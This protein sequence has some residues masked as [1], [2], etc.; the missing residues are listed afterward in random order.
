LED[1][2]AED[3]IL[4]DVHAESGFADYFIICTGTSERQLNALADAVDET[5]RKQHGLKSP[6]L[7]GHA[8]HGWVLVDFN[9][10]IIHLFSADKRKHYRLEELWHTGKTVL[11]IK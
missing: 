11:R 1:K 10:L 4:L 7:E 9:N 8:E 3:I 6:R 2:K 5:G